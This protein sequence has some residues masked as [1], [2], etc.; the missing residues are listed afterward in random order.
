MIR[1][2]FALIFLALYAVFVVLP[3]ALY[4][5]IIGS[6]DSL[7]WAGRAGASWTIR[8]AGV[9][10]RSEGLE[11]IPAKPCVFAANHVSNIDPPA[12][13]AAIPRRIAIL[14]K[15]SLFSIPIVGFSFRLAHFVPINRSDPRDAIASIELATKYLQQGTSYL[16]YPEGTRSPDGRL[17]PFKRA[18]FVLPIRAAVPVVPV[19]CS[20]AHRVLRRN[21]WFIQP[22][23][24]VVRFCPSIDAAAFG[25]EQR[26]ALADAVHGAI[27][28]ALPEDQRPASPSAP[29]ASGLTSGDER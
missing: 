23:E 11:N 16:I 1:T 7:F 10:V 9:R 20:G 5:A 8:L 29:S 13:V 27:A 4:T 17:R 2:I 15:R 28:Q 19:A 26:G 3:L 14:A 22:G 6:A 18:G 21:A 24:L 25:E 12:I